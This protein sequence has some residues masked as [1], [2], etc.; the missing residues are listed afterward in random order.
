V[1]YPAYESDQG[2]DLHYLGA[3][4]LVLLVL[5]YLKAIRDRDFSQGIFLEAP[6]DS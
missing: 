6:Y 2:V 1:D 3:Q 5:F 4:K